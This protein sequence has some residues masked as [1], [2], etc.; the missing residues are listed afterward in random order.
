M[1]GFESQNGRSSTW[2]RHQG[3]VDYILSSV[4]SGHTHN[5]MLMLVARSQGIISL[6]DVVKGWIIIA[7]YFTRQLVAMAMFI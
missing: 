7:Q 2:L 6:T 4:T 3:V 1:Q 5:V